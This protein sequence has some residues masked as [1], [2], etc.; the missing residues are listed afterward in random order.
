[1]AEGSGRHS[2]DP[3]MYPFAENL[4]LEKR[5]GELDR[6]EGL[7]ALIQAL[8]SAVD[9]EIGVGGYPNITIIDG[10]QKDYTKRLREIGDRRAYLASQI[11]R[12]VNRGY[13]SHDKGYALIDKLVYKTRDFEEIYESFFSQV[14]DS[15]ALSRL[16]RGYKILPYRKDIL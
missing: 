11:M 9:H 4:L 2:V 12:A 10:R 14:S 13:L 3:A 5:R 7:M 6:V 1:L 16:L 15:N 8:N